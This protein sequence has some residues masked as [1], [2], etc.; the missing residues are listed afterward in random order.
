MHKIRRLQKGSS[1]EAFLNCFARFI[2][3]KPA[4]AKPTFDAEGE[5]SALELRYAS[6][7]LDYEVKGFQYLF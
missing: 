5:Q 4:P 3:V 6:L 7:N 2:G 1:S